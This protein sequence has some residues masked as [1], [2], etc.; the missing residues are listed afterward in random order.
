M[1]IKNNMLYKL[2]CFF[3]PRQKWLLKKIP[4]TWADKTHLI[5][6]ILYECIVHFVEGERCFETIRWDSG[7]DGHKECAD[8]IRDCYDWIKVRRPELKKR[9]DNII[10]AGF[11]KEELLDLIATLNSNKR[12]YEE[13]YPGLN[14]LENELYEKD[15]YYLTGIVKYRN[16]LW[17]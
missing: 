16:Y 5:P 2:R 4:N 6:E 1:N 14:D 7:F 3:N 8:F 13:M 17:T 9:I 11:S 10:S 15:T 12:T